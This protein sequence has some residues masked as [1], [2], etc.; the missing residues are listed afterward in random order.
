MDA[1][2][3]WNTL[4][5]GE[6]RNHEIV[7]ELNQTNKAIRIADSGIGFNPEKVSILLAPNETDKDGDETQIGEKGV[8]L[9]F[10]I[11][12]QTNSHLKQNPSLELTVAK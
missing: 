2:N 10:A 5:K 7:L 6:K 1:I 3:K 9:K 8:G 12:P 4:H 11:F